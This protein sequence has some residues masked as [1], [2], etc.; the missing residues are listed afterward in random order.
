ML[1]ER[2]QVDSSSNVK[3]QAEHE[4]FMKIFVSSNETIRNVIQVMNQTGFRLVL[5]VDKDNRLKGT[6][7]DGDIRRGFL[8][9]I[10]LE[11]QASEILHPRPIV[12][13]NS[14]SRTKALEIMASEGLLHIPIINENFQV[15]GLHSRDALSTYQKREN[16]FFILAGGKGRRLLPATESV[17]KPML[18]IEGKPIL[19]HIIDRAKANGFS[20]FVIAVQH[21]GE[22]IESYFKDGSEFGVKIRYIREE[23]PLGTAGALSLLDNFPDLPIVVSNGDL[24]T[25]MDYGLILDYH[26][27]NRA[28]ATM[29]VHILEMRNPY[30]VV[31]VKE[32]DIIGY[33]EKPVS[34]VLINAGVYVLEPSVLSLLSKSEYCDM[35]AL[36]DLLRNRE[37]RSIVFPV[38]EK[39]IDI[40]TPENLLR[41]I[42]WE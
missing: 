26:L 16:I 36:F 29:A 34:N 13:D 20:H 21:L 11:S 9:N 4:D 12:V 10:Q 17:P 28:S 14:V 40:G 2:I 37:E 42:N 23:K 19:E 18:Q 5:V 3:M 33:L 15:V 41:A 27:K 39:W 31:Q 24:M 6:I 35:P 32:I 25:E 1:E 8:G 30:G 38:H 7:T 22:Q